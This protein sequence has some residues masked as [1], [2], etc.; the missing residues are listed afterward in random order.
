MTKAVAAG[1]LSMA[2]CLTAC[3]TSEQFDL[4][5]GQQAYEVIPP[6]R[7]EANQTAYR[8]NP[9]DSLTITVFRE[10][11]LGVKEAPVESGG[12]LVLPLIGEVH[13]A[14]RTS[15]ELA[16]DIETALRQRGLRQPR[17]SVIIAST[18]SQNVVVDGAV[19][20]AGVY[21]LLGQTTLLQSIAMAKGASKVAKL[22]RVAIFRTINGVRSGALFDVMAI[23]EGRMADPYI[24]SGDYVIVGTSSS[25]SRY[26]DILAVLP[27]FATFVAL[28]R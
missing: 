8:I 25:K 23:R 10:A 15:S 21:Q 18:K 14:G 1:L 12:G 27:T 9:S 11:E 28:V 3:A 20:E 26:Y 5:Q 22:D 19:Q 7:I 16:A 17:V 24:Q 2:V 13:A 4:P 6:Q